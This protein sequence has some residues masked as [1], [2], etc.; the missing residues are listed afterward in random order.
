[1]DLADAEARVLNETHRPGSAWEKE[2]A[3]TMVSKPRSSKK[4]LPALGLL[5]AASLALG[6]GVVAP[7]SALAAAPVNTSLP[8][9]SPSKPHP[10]VVETTTN[11][12]WTGSPTSYTYNWQR[13]DALGGSCVF[14]AGAT[15]ATY[16]PVKADA[17]HTL[18]AAVT[19][20]NGEGSG[21]AWSAPT[22]LVDWGYWYSCQN[23]GAGA[24]LYEDPA[25]SK[26]GGSKAFAWT[27]LGAAATGLTMHREGPG[28]KG[29]FVINF[30]PFGSEVLIECK[31]Q[32]ASGT[33]A[34]PAG[35]AAG[36]TSLSSFTLTGCSVL[37][38]GGCKVHEPVTFNPLTG[39][40]TEFSGKTALEFAPTRAE[41]KG[42]LTNVEFIG[43][44]CS[45]K[46]IS[47][48]ITGSF[49]GVVDAA[50]STLTITE[51][52]TNMIS[53]RRPAT[54]SGIATLATTAGE[55]LKIAN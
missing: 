34:N 8:V 35:G 51:A 19:A 7:A 28:T 9:V 42:I 41:D 6:V 49:T 48:P 10:G 11:G 3:R 44:S 14:I 33:I 20:H 52:S 1:L 26:E 21:Q 15:S 39:H 16:T 50:T 38:A 30:K 47:Y 53:V 54:M 37:F 17:G 27:K 32:A 24:G 45:V 46:G 18:V 23:V 43:T 31:T 12:T 22:E 5:L 2:F 36:T 40:I 25:C 55:A 13:C 4:S 29:E